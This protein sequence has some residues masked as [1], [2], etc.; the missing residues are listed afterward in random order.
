[1]LYRDGDIEHPV[2]GSESY[3]LLD[4]GMEHE[5]DDD[6]AYDP[7]VCR[8]YMEVPLNLDEKCDLKNF[9]GINIRAT[10]ESADG[11]MYGVAAGWALKYEG[12]E[13][14]VTALHVAQTLLL[15]KKISLH[16]EIGDFST[17]KDVAGLFSDKSHDFYDP[18]TSESWMASPFP[19]AKSGALVD[20]PKVR[21]GQS[22]PNTDADF[23]AWYLKDST[24]LQVLE[25][26]TELPKV[27][28][29]V[30]HIGNQQNTNGDEIE[31]IISTT[32]VVCA[33]EEDEFVWRYEAG[34]NMADGSSG[35]PILNKK[36]Q[37]VCMLT[38]MGFGDD[39]GLTRFACGTTCLAIKKLL[40][41]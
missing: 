7:S 1:M 39:A 20:T 8:G 34:V 3:K 16:H 41:N 33:S 21:W 32:C 13:M 12:K 17:W 18:C 9:T 37:L 30:F 23:I 38:C 5:F 29:P 22:E 25:L 4:Q 24:G 28:E 26:A 27:G 31:G 10:Y 14:Y 11:Q 19:K 6:E 35:S 15:P 40:E 36:G 2:E